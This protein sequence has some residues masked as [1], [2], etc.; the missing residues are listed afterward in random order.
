MLALAVTVLAGCTSLGAEYRM[1]QLDDLTWAYTR[2]VEWSDFATAHAA[3]I[4]TAGASTLDTSAYKDIKV[5]SYDLIS[6]RSMDNGKSIQ[7]IV[8]I[9]YVHLSDMAERSLDLEEDWTYSDADKR[10]YLRSGFPVFK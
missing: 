9:S 8:R 10:W 7:R 1:N 3:T 5:T 2:A 4:T 6:A